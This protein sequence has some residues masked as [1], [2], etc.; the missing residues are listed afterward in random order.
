MKTCTG[1]ETE[2]PLDQFPLKGSK[3]KACK[4]AY[5]RAYYEKNKEKIKEQTREYRANNKDRER[6]DTIVCCKCE[7]EK[8]SSEFRSDR[9]T[10]LSCE[11]Q[12]CRQYR[13]DNPEKG[14]TWISNNRERFSELRAQWHQE[15][16]PE[17]YKKLQE[18]YKN[19]PMYRKIFD[20][21]SSIRNVIR[22]PKCKKTKDL[23][24][25][26]DT[27]I[28]WLQ[29]SFEMGMNMDNYGEAWVVD[30]VVPLRVAQE[31]P[32]LFDEVA[33]WYNIMPVSK[34][35]NLEKNM[36]ADTDQA[37][38]QFLRLKEFCGNRGI[39]L[40][41]NYIQILIDYTQVAIK[42]CKNCN[43]YKLGNDFREHRWKCIIC[44]REENLVRSHQNKEKNTEYRAKNR[45][46]RNKA[47]SEWYHQNKE[48]LS[49]QARERYQKCK[50]KTAE[51][52]AT[53]TDEAKRINAYRA[54]VSKM[55][56]GTQKR[57][58]HVTYK[59]GDLV[60]WCKFS[61][62]DDDLS[63]E[64]YGDEWIVDFVVP[65]AHVKTTPELYDML[66][67]W[68]N[69]AAILPINKKA[70]KTDIDTA[71]IREHLEKLEYYGQEVNKNYLDY[72]RDILLRETPV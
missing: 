21:R 22:K 8:A 27:F 10:C 50:D 55:I 37:T 65:L 4:I 70:K 60:E 44:E 25:T 20:Y 36:Y 35:Y 53:Q 62:D 15:H 41:E 32:E 47:S 19:D 3:C 51:K 46:Q 61:L 71:Q 14:Q 68:Y 23:G 26:R 12:H 66:T 52:Y 72:L 17:I 33:K 38:R 34:Q 11:R 2:K 59:I 1:C 63:Q 30:H 13:R 31:Y 67:D 9:N 69:I 7:E 40:P 54:A 49:E 58:K 43:E 48:E 16:K 28:E 45:E 5:N 29:R 39:E 24:C 64:N 18:R 56:K 6:P 42:Q 57:C